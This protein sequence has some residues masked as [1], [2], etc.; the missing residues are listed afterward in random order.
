[1]NEITLQINDDLRVA[2]DA[3][4]KLNEKDL[5]VVISDVEAVQRAII[6]AYGICSVLQALGNNDV[7]PKKNEGA[8]WF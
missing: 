1:M 5:G 3:I 4:K 2:I 8:I 7:K 6:T